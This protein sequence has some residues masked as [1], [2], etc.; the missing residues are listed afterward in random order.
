MN[1]E[2]ERAEAAASA[3][4]PAAVFDQAG[5]HSVSR[6]LPRPESSRFTASNLRPEWNRTSK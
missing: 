1:G 3:I 4:A 2:I 5:A 6:A